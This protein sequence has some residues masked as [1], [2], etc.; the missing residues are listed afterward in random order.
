MAIGIILAIVFV[1]LTIVAAVI[2]YNPVQT[3]RLIRRP[4]RRKSYEKEELR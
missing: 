3:N 1:V 4:Q 2:A